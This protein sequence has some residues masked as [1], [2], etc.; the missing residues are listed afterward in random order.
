LSS[1]LHGG[2][3]R[4]AYVALITLLGIGLFVLAA[5]LAHTVWNLWPV[6]EEVAARGAADADRAPIDEALQNLDVMLLDTNLD[7]SE[8]QAYLLLIAA[9]GAVGSFIHTATSFTTYVG[10][11]QFKLSWLWWYLLRIVIGTAVAL[12]LLI[13]VLGGLVTISSN[14]NTV[15][16]QSLNPYAIAALSGLAGWFSKT[17]ADKLEEIFEVVL[18]NAKD[19][20][21]A[22]KLDQQ[23]PEISTV[24]AVAASSGTGA[25]LTIA[26]SNLSTE[27]V[28][29]IDG[30]DHEATFDA[31][32][33]TLTVAVA[34]MP[35]HGS[36][37]VVTNRSEHT[38]AATVLKSSS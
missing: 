1:T 9:F 37:V 30:V 6:V 8:G 31:E 32:E 26:G 22:D 20:A 27:S 23:T 36:H 35:T 19:A 38:S 25:V 21:R 24:T 7:V 12:T 16:A 5:A 11:R 15:E 29:T 28:V 17:A 34:D 3:S 4:R 18:S 33:H 13:A 10:N 14:S 2:Q